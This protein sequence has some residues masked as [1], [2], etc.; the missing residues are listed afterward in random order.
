MQGTWCPLFPDRGNPRHGAA[1][2]LP[3]SPKAE[4]GPRG[5]IWQ[6]RNMASWR[7]EDWRGEQQAG[8]P[9]RSPEKRGRRLK[10]LTQE[11]KG[12]LSSRNTAE[13]EETPSSPG[14]RAWHS[15]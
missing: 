11:P 2:T 7:R 4:L 8:A 6:Q 15:P 12:S 9:P 1:K 3:L 13:A 10:A 5:P 14:P